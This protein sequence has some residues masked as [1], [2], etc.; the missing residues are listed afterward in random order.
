M[1]RRI[2]LALASAFLLI[3]CATPG[4]VAPTDGTLA[5]NHPASACFT[6]EWQA[7]IYRDAVLAMA[8]GT[9][10]GELTD[11]ERRNFLAAY[12][13]AGPPTGVMYERIGF[14]EH[15]KTHSVM[16]AFI[17]DGCV[18]TT[19]VLPRALFFAMARRTLPALPRRESMADQRSD[20]RDQSLAPLP[21]R[22]GGV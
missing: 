15:P 8:E 22:R 14:F 2:L 4:D 20:V 9:R 12:N 18:W 1:T 16:V 17:E 21:G 5:P 10:Y 6:P 13:T 19:G 11:A 3:G 7:E